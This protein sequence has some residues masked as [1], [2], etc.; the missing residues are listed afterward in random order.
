MN[1]TIEKTKVLI[2]DCETTGTSNT[3]EIIEL[4]WVTSVLSMRETVACFTAPLNAS[5]QANQLYTYNERFNPS[6]PINPHA[7]KVHGIGKM[8]LLSCRPSSEANIPENTK[9]IVG[10][11]VAV[12]DHRMLGKPDVLCIDTLVL[13][14][15][16][17]KL[18]LITN[19]DDEG[20]DKLDVL[21]TH[22]FPEVAK[23]L[24]KPLH[25]ALD[26]CYKVI[27]LLSV[28]LEKFPTI[29]TWDALFELQ[30]KGK[31]K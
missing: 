12:F 7:Y 9:Y 5:N 21:I 29:D 25:S 8:K 3:D 22:Y 23:T 27:L 17:R 14:R 31:K 13:V 28:I 24:I 4:A 1:L 20:K 6:V 10:H 18:G 2:L 15:T 11:Q 19:N 30:T 16:L 26:D